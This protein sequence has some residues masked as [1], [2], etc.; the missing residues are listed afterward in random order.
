MTFDPGTWG[1]PFWKVIH[2]VAY[3]LDHLHTQNPKEAQ[4][5]WKKFID[6]ITAGLPCSKCESHFRNFQSSLP[7]KSTDLSFLKWT[8]AAHNAV[9]KRN[10]KPEAP[11]SD[12]I[13]AYDDGYFYNQDSKGPS[14]SLTGWQIGFVLVC[15]VLLVCIVSFSLALCKRRKA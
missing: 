8:I 13:R 10:R 1:P 4:S 11:E 3:Y 7:T 9:R 14:V 12:V 6:G 2:L 15:V 5:R